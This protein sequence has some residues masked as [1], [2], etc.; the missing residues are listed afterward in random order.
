MTELLLHKSGINVHC[1]P[2]LV[3]T[4]LCFLSS[5]MFIMGKVYVRYRLAVLVPLQA[6][7]GLSMVAERFSAYCFA[8]KLE[9]LPVFFCKC[10]TWQGLTF[11]VKVVRSEHTPHMGFSRPVMITHITASVCKCVAVVCV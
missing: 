5:L 10:T 9:W 8:Y 7:Y 4:F 6:D 2:S 3:Q 11:S 1:L